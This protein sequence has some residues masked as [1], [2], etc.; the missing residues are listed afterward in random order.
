[1]CLLIVCTSCGGYFAVP[2]VGIVLFKL[3]EYSE[4][5]TSKPLHLP[6]DVNKGDQREFVRNHFFVRGLS[7]EPFLKEWGKP[8]KQGVWLEKDGNYEIEYCEPECGE[9]LNKV[10]VYEKKPGDQGTILFF[11]ENIL[12]A[13]YP[14]KAYQEGKRE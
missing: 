11:Y 5:I 1:M 2:E 3:V 4:K 8:D 12:T 6:E 7:P 9:T 13:S 14:W 10:W